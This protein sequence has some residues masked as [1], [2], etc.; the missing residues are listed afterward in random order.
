MSKNTKERT[1]PSCSAVVYSEGSESP[2]SCSKESTI[3]VRGMPYCHAHIPDVSHHWR[4]EP[5]SI[6][7]CEGIDTVALEGGIVRE[8]FEA[9]REMLDSEIISTENRKVLEKA[10]AAIVTEEQERRQREL[11]PPGF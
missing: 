5:A 2:T 8:L 1:V 7:A 10:V 11:F 6:A 4:R 3:D 9:A